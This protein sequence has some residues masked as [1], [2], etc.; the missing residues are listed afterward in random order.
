VFLLAQADESISTVREL[1]EF[2]ALP[3]L[4]GISR[5]DA[6]SQRRQRLVGALGFAAVS[7]ALVL[8]C[9]MIISIESLANLRA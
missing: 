8:A 2:V 4:G 3:V 5:V 7:I 1:K 9:V 6:G